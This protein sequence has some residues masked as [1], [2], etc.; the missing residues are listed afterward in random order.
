MGPEK[1]C[2][3][4]ERR[5]LVLHAL[6]LK[7]LATTE[8]VTSTYGLDLESTETDLEQCRREGLVTSR[9]DVWSLTSDGR[10]AG[11]RMLAEE[12][13]R[14]SRQRK[15]PVGPLVTIQYDRF[16]PLNREMLE[17]CTRWQ[18]R[19]HDPVE[20]ND[21]SDRSYDAAVIAD[22][23]NAHRHAQLICGQLETL[24]SRFA[25][26]RSGFDY[27]LGRIADGAIEWFTKPT[28]LSYHT[29]W[30]EL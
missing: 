23:E 5:L 12:L 21:H 17:I 7:G 22:L 20:L 19:N 9:G 11:E 28:I 8:T 24:L 10:G 30:F 18:V 27:A 14:C 15:T 16:V 13:D 6:R 4:S 2:E 1:P 3:P 29:L 25:R 26:Y